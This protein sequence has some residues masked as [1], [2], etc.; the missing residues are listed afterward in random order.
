MWFIVLLAT[1]HGHEVPSIG[2]GIANYR[3]ASQAK[4][5][6]DASRRAQ[7]LLK[8]HIHGRYSCMYHGEPDIELQHAPKWAF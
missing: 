3:F 7:A 8:I 6:D 1:V 4:C 5:I 2:E